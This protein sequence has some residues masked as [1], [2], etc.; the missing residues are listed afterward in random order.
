LHWSP[1]SGGGRDGYNTGKKSL[2]VPGVGLSGSFTSRLYGKKRKKY[3]A[4]FFLI[5]KILAFFIANKSI[6]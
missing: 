2:V 1:T 6:I 3:P 5:R 4:T